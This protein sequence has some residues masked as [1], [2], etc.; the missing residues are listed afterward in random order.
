MSISWGETRFQC[1]VREEV[2]RAIRVRLWRPCM[3]LQFLRAH[4]IPNAQ[5]EALDKDR[6]DGGK[7]F[8]DWM[9]NRYG[10]EVMEVVR[11][12]LVP[13]H[14]VSSAAVVESAWA[15]LGLPAPAVLPL[16]VKGRRV[17]ESWG[18]G[19]SGTSGLNDTGLF[20]GIKAAE[21]S[22]GS[23][24]IVGPSYIPIDFERMWRQP[25][26]DAALLVSLVHAERQEWG[27]GSSGPINAVFSDRGPYRAD[28]ASVHLAVWSGQGTASAAITPLAKWPP[29]EFLE[30]H[31]RTPTS[32]LDVL[33][34]DDRLVYG[35]RRRAGLS[36]SSLT[37]TPSCAIL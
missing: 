1:A 36:P 24:A 35:V 4:G 22:G 15:A 20:F 28:P 27:K 26:L 7:L 32:P 16:P 34:D 2:E 17:S 12:V 30:G 10:R 21:G 13:V 25:S 29:T 3:V 19:G 33:F 23:G 31:S 11:A 5:L 37:P 8:D 14:W 18:S 9:Q 6:V